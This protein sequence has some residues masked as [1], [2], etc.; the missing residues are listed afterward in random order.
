VNILHYLQ[1]AL[2]LVATVTADATEWHML[3]D[4]SRLEFFVNYSGQEAPGLF[5]RFTT[6]L[7]FDPAEPT[8]SRLV[9][10]VETLS[11]DLDSADIN[12]AIA[13]PEW[14]DFAQFAEARFVS[15]SI[16]RIDDERFVATGSLRLKG[17]D[18]VVDVPFTWREAD[19][20]ATMRGELYLR[21]GTFAIG[22]GEWAGS[23]VIG[24]KVRVRFKVTLQGEVE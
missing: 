10:T 15:D 8:N 7:R 12:E 6:E 11:A 2:L 23:D 16:A 4:A 1:I 21:R 3:A 14:F 13:G 17:I 19:G 24:D 5:R 20:L 18:Q 22:T 9:V